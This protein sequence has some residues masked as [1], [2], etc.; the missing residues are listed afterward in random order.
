MDLPLRLASKNGCAGSCA[1]ILSVQP[2]PE[3]LRKAADGDPVALD[4]LFE[5]NLPG[6][7]AF[8]RSRLGA[9]LAARESAT[10]LAQSVCREVLQD[11]DVFEFRG[12]AA[13][14]GWMYKQAI[15]KI[16][17]RSR[18]HGRDCRDAA[19][20]IA[21]GSSRED[22][23]PSLIACYGCIATPSRH[24]SAREELERFEEALAT[25]PE[26]QRDAI[27]MSR[28]MGMDYAEIADVLGISPSA[29]RGLVARGL[30]ALV[31][32]LD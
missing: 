17:D 22:D 3:T 32:Q 25:L 11:Q 21:P 6:L 23:L 14:R 30:A 13:F 19:R 5:R 24:A 18:Y 26:N 15:R 12:E 8:I 9:Q 7:V 4:S 16:L 10:D 1:T 20:E 31:A 27:S 2:D 28:L 29:V